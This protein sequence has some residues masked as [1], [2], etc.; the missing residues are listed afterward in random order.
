MLPYKENISPISAT[1]QDVMS[2]ES[3][4]YTWKKKQDKTPHYG[5]IAQDVEKIF[6]RLVSTDDKGFKYVNYIEL[7]PVLLKAVQ[8][9]QR[10]IE[11]LKN[12]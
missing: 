9:Q 5:L 7:I 1:M 4:E 12:Q 11:K 2:L 6:P 8:E 10:E 3:V